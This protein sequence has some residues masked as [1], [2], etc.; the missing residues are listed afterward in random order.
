VVVTNFNPHYPLI[1]FATGDMSAIMAGQSP[2]GRTNKRIKGWMG[3]ADQATKVRGM[4]VRP[5]QVADLVSKHEEVM[6]VRLQ[7][8]QINGQDNLNVLCE[9]TVISSELATVIADSVRSVLHI[10]G[11]VVLQEIGSLP[12]DG[13][14]IHDQREY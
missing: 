13:L 4:F 11:E 10:R 12:N 3:R 14:V 8:T 7:V 2:C 6:K 5:E 9:A 1:R